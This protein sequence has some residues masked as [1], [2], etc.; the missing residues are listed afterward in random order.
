MPM[1]FHADLHIHGRFSAATSSDMNFKNLAKGSE[2][3]GVDLVATGDCLHPTWLKEIKDMEKVAEFTNEF[4][5]QIKGVV[6]I[7][8]EF[9]IRRY[10]I[11]R[12]LM[13]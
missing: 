3:K 6:S 9:L 4:L 13:V 8:T 5:P 11:E 10:K 1:Q 2:Q 7:N 12:S